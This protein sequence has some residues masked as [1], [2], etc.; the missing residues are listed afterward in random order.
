VVITKLTGGLGN[1]IFQYAVGRAL[2]VRRSTS[3]KLDLA[4]FGRSPKRKYRLGRFSIAASIAYS[5]DVAQFTCANRR[6]PLRQMWHWYQSRLPYWRRAVLK[7]RHRHF[8]SGVLRAPGSVYLIGYWQSEKYF[9]D[10]AHL[11]RGELTLRSPP[12]RE[13][14]RVARVARNTRSVAV[15]CRRGDYVGNPR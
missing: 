3:L 6:R 4:H 12:S 11:L 14:M 2:S 8:D 1:Q 5:R 10:I 7:E 15:H 13:T 9:R